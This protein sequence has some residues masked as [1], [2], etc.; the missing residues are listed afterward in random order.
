MQYQ[1]KSGA[2]LRYVGLTICL[3]KP[4]TTVSV[5][6]TST[7]GSRPTNKLGVL[8]IS[9]IF[10]S[11]VRRVEWDLITKITQTIADVLFPLVVC[12]VITGNSK[13]PK[14]EHNN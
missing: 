2:N 7:R 4:G 6:R 9:L 5:V 1:L 13:S 11:G 14:A 10:S 8:I 12:L 3:Y